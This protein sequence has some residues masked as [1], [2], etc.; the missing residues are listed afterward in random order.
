MKSEKCQA[1]G[2]TY[3]SHNNLPRPTQHVLCVTVYL[4]PRFAGALGKTVGVL[5]SRC[6]A[7]LPARGEE[8]VGYSSQVRIGFTAFLKGVDTASQTDIQLDLR[9][10]IGHED[11]SLD[12]SESGHLSILLSRC[13]SRRGSTWANCNVIRVIKQHPNERLLESEQ[14]AWHREAD[15]ER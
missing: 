12:V 15:R 2:R 5:V 8:E 3:L 11:F 4:A 6:H 13:A 1:K 7:L 14:G 9:V 10:Q